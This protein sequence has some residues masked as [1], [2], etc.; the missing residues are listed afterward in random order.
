MTDAEYEAWLVSDGRRVLLFEIETDTPRFLSTVGY[1]TR[2][3]ESPPN[4]N[5]LACI[6]RGFAFRERLSLDGNASIGA[7]DIEVHNEDGSLD[8]WLLDVWVNRRIRVYLGDAS[9][10]RADFRLEFDGMTAGIT[11]SSPSRLNISL[12]NKMERLNTPATEAV[13]GGTTPNKDRLLPVMFGENHNV[14]P[15]LID[16]ANHEY[17]IHNGAMERIIEVRD[18]GVPLSLVTPYLATGKFRLGATPAGAITVSAQGKT[19]YQNTVAGIVRT[20]AT[21]YGT[22]SERLALSDI[23]VAAMNAFDAAHPQPVGI[24]LPDRTNV[25]QA[26]Q[27]LAASVGAQVVFSRRGLLRIVKVA[28]PGA[29]VP[30]Q[31]DLS[32]YLVQTLSI[33]QRPEVVSGV[34]LGY[35]KNWLVQTSLNTGIPPEHKDM[36][37][38]EWLTVTAR[39]A[40]VAAAYRLFGEIPQRD[41]LLLR[42]VDAQAEANRLL[43]LWSV[44]RTVYGI[45]GYPRLLTL[46]L[47]QPVVLYGDR[48]GLGDGKE[49]IVIGV[50]R[51]WIGG[52]CTVE[53]LV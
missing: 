53:V 51:D 26:C 48:W 38:Q 6:A 39:D 36:F 50:D 15:L 30:T 13:L 24:S 9:W 3:S 49:G 40:A 52:R 47:G 1:M 16:P 28:L 32:D 45:T 35:C 33:K 29:G 41:T 10:P 14:E 4:L 8:S 17:M 25:M 34:K 44:P 19:P 27:Q 22:P 43:A 18:N 5:Y 12:R 11:S 20:L 31:I 2:P 37:A 46:E 42:G 23:D 21:E 7:G